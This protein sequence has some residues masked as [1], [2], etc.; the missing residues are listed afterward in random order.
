MV[1]TEG[2]LEAGMGSAGIHQ[3]GVAELTDV[4]EP[5]NGGRVECDERRAVQPDVVPERVAND[6]GFGRECHL[7][8]LHAPTL[9][10]GM[11]AG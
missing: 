11:R 3:K 10:R 6:F 9:A 4:A 1:G 7:V 2:V 5:L 8:Y